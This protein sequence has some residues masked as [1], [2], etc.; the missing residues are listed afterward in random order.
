MA[1][2]VNIAFDIKTNK[3]VKSID[4][5]LKKIKDLKELVDKPSEIS[6]K[7]SDLKN[8]EKDVKQAKKSMKNL[9][10]KSAVQGLEEIVEL[11]NRLGNNLGK[12]SKMDYASIQ[13][14]KE[15]LSKAK[16]EA[17]RLVST[18]T[19]EDL[20]KS[21]DSKQITE[22]MVDIKELKRTFGA[23][24]KDI[25]GFSEEFIK[26][27]KSVEQLSRKIE[28]QKASISDLVSQ[29]GKGEDSA[30][31]LTNSLEDLGNK[32]YTALKNA[33][34]TQLDRLQREFKDAEV[35]YKSFKKELEKPVQIKLPDVK[36]KDIGLK[37]RQKTYAYDNFGLNLGKSQNLELPKDSELNKLIAMSNKVSSMWKSLDGS[38]MDER[39]FSGLLEELDKVN[40][41]LS[42]LKSKLSNKDTLSTDELVKFNQEMIDSSKSV[43]ILESA[44]KSL[45][46]DS[47]KSL[48]E[49]ES[50]ARQL[51]LLF[52]KTDKIKTL[53]EIN[54]QG[55]IIP[56][57]EELETS[58]IKMSYAL[59]KA[60]DNSDV[61]AVARLKEEIKELN[62]VY[63]N[64]LK[65]A[66]KT[67][68]VDIGLK[69]IKTSFKT[70]SGINASI[71]KSQNLQAPKVEVIKQPDQSFSKLEM[72]VS[73][74]IDSM[75]SMGESLGKTSKLD[76]RSLVLYL[77]KMNELVNK[78]EEFK[79]LFSNPDLMKSFSKVELDNIIA[80]FKEYSKVVNGVKRDISSFSEDGIKSIKK[81]E[82]NS[83][84]LET[85]KA[86]IDEIR[87]TANLTGKFELVTDLDKLVKSVN[88]VNKSLS[89]GVESADYTIFA[90]A[91]NRIK[92]LTSLVNNY[93]K[94]V[95]KVKKVK[96]ISVTDIG[97]KQVSKYTGKSQTLELPQFKLKSDNVSL[98]IKSIQA[99]IESSIGKLKYSTFLNNDSIK[100]NINTL[101]SLNLKLEEMKDKLKNINSESSFIDLNNDLNK[102]KTQM[103]DFNVDSPIVSLTRLQNG[104]M[105]LN[106]LSS[107]FGFVIN[108]TRK[109][110]EEFL[111]LEDA[112]YNLGVVANKSNI[113]IKAMRYEMLE[114]AKGKPFSALEI[115][116]SLDDVVR[117][118]QSF[119][120]AMDIVNSSMQLASASGE[121]LS[122]SVYLINKIMVALKTNT[123][124]ADKVTQSLHA[125]AIATASDMTSLGTSAKQYV[126]ALGGLSA[127]TKRSGSDL[128][129]Y[130]VNLV[131]LGSTFSGILANLGRAGEQQGE[132]LL[133]PYVARVA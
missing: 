99:Q 104:M 74:T 100:A 61:N 50:M 58:I 35:Q 108:N 56:Q 38:N 55:G 130:R 10:P 17:D 51:D 52:S 65:T 97:L 26:S 37:Q 91:E 89:K 88:L 21:L 105:A 45:G 25:Q 126:G 22:L 102:I 70:L 107:T 19:D 59:D 42:E 43:G 18:L 114:M 24:A 72:T 87:N 1:R 12:N 57:V 15:N 34:Y 129:E 7:T 44:I 62:K 80:D 14:Y 63:D 95:K 81:L 112:L 6:I 125:T 110:F 92:N 68:T 76:D 113:E 29:Y 53:G 124:D 30:K 41:K 75:K 11:A 73:R 5:L 4:D 27:T 128:D 84:S 94:E 54:K 8:I 77:K 23:T 79:T 48:K 31:S 9:V 132:H 69:N 3:A 116:K 78:G 121:E 13:M 109:D 133:C 36:P 86:R 28:N 39:V 98:D 20:F 90:K 16:K 96:D 119:K 127:L 85:L 32:L 49:V 60:F 131:K 2:T 93:E 101:S 64:L 118:G 122:D 46:Y 47:I 33:D 115:T 71:G 120:G 40:S 82:Q 123:K 111:K 103:K 83:R 106:E 117:T 67:S 66:S